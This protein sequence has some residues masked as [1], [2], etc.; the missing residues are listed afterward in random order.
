MEAADCGSCCACRSCQL[1][2]SICRTFLPIRAMTGAYQASRAC[3]EGLYKVVASFSFFFFLS[4]SRCSFVSSIFGV[5]PQ[6]QL[7]LQRTCVRFCTTRKEIKQPFVVCHWECLRSGIYTVDS[8][9]QPR[10]W[11][12]RLLTVAP[13]LHVVALLPLFCRRDAVYST[14]SSC[15]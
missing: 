1:W 4:L 13:R 3:A 15:I 12:G 2:H 11:C 7:V 8:R 5:T 9:M 14:K 10:L 6:Q